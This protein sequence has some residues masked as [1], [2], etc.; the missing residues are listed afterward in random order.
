MLNTELLFAQLP[1]HKFYFRHLNTDQGLSSGLINCIY[2]DHNGYLWIGTFN[3]L[4]CFDGSHFLMWNVNPGDSLSLQSN[5]IESIC[6]DRKGNIWCSTSNGVSKFN[7]KR[8]ETYRFKNEVTGQEGGGAYYELLSTKSGEIVASYEFGIYIYDETQNKFIGYYENKSTGALNGNYIYKNCFVEDTILNGIWCGVNT[9]I[10]FFDLRSHTFYSKDF[11]PLNIPILNDHNC[12]AFA[13][14]N[15]HCLIF[16]DV[17]TQ[18]LVTYDIKTKS[19][20]RK[21]TKAWFNTNL[22]LATIFVDKQNNKWISTWQYKMVFE[23]SAGNDYSLKY[24]PGDYYSISTDFFWSAYQEDDS[25]IYLGTMNGISF[26]NYQRNFFSIIKLPEGVD[27]KT[28]YYA[29]MILCCDSQNNIWM[30]PSYNSILKYNVASGTFTDYGY[31]NRK[32]TNNQRKKVWSGAASRDKLFFGT[33][34]GILTYNVSDSSFEYDAHCPTDSFFMNRAFKRMMLNSYNELWFTDFLKNV[35]CYNIITKEFKR[36]LIDSTKPGCVPV[37]WVVGFYEDHSRN[38]YIVCGAEHLVKFNRQANEFEKIFTKK[39]K[40]FPKS[41]NAVPIEDNDKNFWVINTDLGLTEFNLEKGTFR[42]YLNESGLSHQI[43]GPIIKNGNELWLKFYDQ[44][45]IF[46]LT[47]KKASNFSVNHARNNFNYTNGLFLMPD[48]KILSES[49]NSFII[50][51]PDNRVTRSELDPV[52][53][54]E[55]RSSD[56]VF[57]FPVKEHTYH[58]NYNQNYFEF[59]FSTFSFLKNN[60]ITFEYKLEGFN[61]NW[62]ECV[63]RQTA[64]YTNVPGGSYVFRVRAKG[65]D[66]IWHNCNNPVS[67]HINKVFFQTVWFK[68]LIIVAFAV[69]LFWYIRMLRLRQ[70]KKEVSKAI[71][72]FASSNIRENRVENIL[73]DI[74]HNIINRTDLVDCVIYLLDSE[75]NI[76]VQKAAFGDKNPDA[77][78]IINAIEIPVGRGIVGAVAEQGRTIV[79]NDTSKDSRYIVDDESRLSELAVP[80][81]NDGKV[82]GVIDSEHPRRNF[83]TKNHI[84]VL[85]TIAS[86]TASKIAASIEHERAEQKQLEL[87]EA[88][89]KMTELRLIALQSQMNPHFIFNCL[90][91]IDN[92][93]LKKESEQASH[94]LNQFAK[95]IRQILNQSKQNSI[96][97]ANEIKWLKIY[98]ELEQLNIENG[99]EFTVT[100]ENNIDLNEVEIPPMILQ[101][102]IENAIRHGLAPKQGAK[103]LSVH[104]NMNENNLECTIE[105]NGI[106]REAALELKRKKTEGYESKGLEVTSERLDIL[107]TRIEENSSIEFF[108]LFDQSGNASGTKVII[109]IPIE[110]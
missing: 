1:E 49:Y 101:P 69:S 24:N 20:S 55:F 87:S 35:Y 11:N 108:D 13:L 41:S 98:V 33:T 12:E 42:S 3:G 90:N 8:F 26:T 48:G 110:I 57:I 46:D 6:E 74:T 88:S 71:G 93:I 66:G 104:F 60:N 80:I 83:F 29:S 79:V 72:Y 39:I 28:D 107:K 61:E 40:G 16:N 50:F 37:D 14:D 96:T 32:G 5:V 17:T 70:R 97:L 54:S 77:Y 109:R 30:A 45:S 25:T 99:F 43:Y 47:T 63:Q 106:G 65:Q 67:I 73:W 7:G 23:D 19:V 21:S 2:K 64:Y 94:Y 102:F 22:E 52:N 15:N 78:N 59:S 82:I 91:V 85:E 86:I 84:A 62:I 34:D 36:F 89:K 75:R 38:T 100:V 105:D 31:I 18:E 10:R 76:L 68:S 27:R 58:F 51:N 44:F 103:K 9:G 92:F 4:N 95:L 56:S 81:I 53:I